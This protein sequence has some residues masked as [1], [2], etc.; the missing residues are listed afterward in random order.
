MRKMSEESIA[1]HRKADQEIQ[2][3]EDLESWLPD[4]L[5]QTERKIAIDVE[6]EFGIPAATVLQY[7]EAGSGQESTHESI[8]KARSS[9][10]L[11]QK[12]TGLQHV[13]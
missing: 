12:P 1:F 13:C 4:H 10:N 7:L 11:M 3:M 6:E 9:L 2:F 5:R 8:C